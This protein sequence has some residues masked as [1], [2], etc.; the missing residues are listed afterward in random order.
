[1]NENKSRAGGGVKQT[2]NLPFFC[3]ANHNILIHT[4]IAR[5]KLVIIFLN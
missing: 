4:V 3:L 1:V 2:K 5:D